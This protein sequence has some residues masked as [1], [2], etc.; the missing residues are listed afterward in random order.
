[1]TQ[2]HRIFVFL[3]AILL[4]VSVLTAALAEGPLSVLYRAGSRLLF[5]TDNATLKASATFT[6]NGMPFKTLDADYLQDGVNSQMALRLLTPREGSAPVATGFTVVG[7]GD[8]AYAI[9][10]AEFLSL[11]RA[12]PFAGR[13]VFGRC[14]LTVHDGTA[15]FYEEP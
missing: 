8:T 10:P 12:T 15:V 6:Y 5:G 2:K 7:N 1:M 13:R 9:D 11:G 14:K 4:I 3:T